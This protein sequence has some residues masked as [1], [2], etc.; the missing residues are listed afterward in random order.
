MVGTTR[1]ERLDREDEE[2]EASAWGGGER[3]MRYWQAKAA[4]RIRPR[5]VAQV[6]LKGGLES[7]VLGEMVLYLSVPFQLAMRPFYRCS[8]ITHMR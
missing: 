1:N 8:V 2:V 4:K 7:L 3:T 6:N 5:C